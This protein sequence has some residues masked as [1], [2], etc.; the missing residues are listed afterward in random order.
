MVKLFVVSFVTS[1]IEHSRRFQW[2]YSLLCLL[3]HL[4]LNIRGGSSGYTLCCV[5]C[6]MVK[7]K[8]FFHIFLKPFKSKCH[9]VILDLLISHVSLCIASTFKIIK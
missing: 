2:L 1:F 9:H 3:L 7:D 6:I 4:L 5:F 8:H